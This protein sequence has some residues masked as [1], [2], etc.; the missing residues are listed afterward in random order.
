MGA[1]SLGAYIRIAEQ[2]LAD[3]PGT[4]QTYRTYWRR[5]EEE[6]GADTPL[7]TILTSQ[8]SAL[9]R[10]SS[11][12]AVVR[13]NTRQGVSAQENFVMAARFLFRSAVEDR[14]IAE[15][16]AAKVPIPK[17]EVSFRRALS[18]AELERLRTLIVRY[19]S[20]P[21]LDL[22]LVRFH[23]ETGAR[24]GGA[25]AL[26]RQDLSREGQWVLLREKGNHSR[27]QPTTSFL[28]PAL[29]L[30][31]QRRYDFGGTVRH[32]EVFLTKNGAPIGRRHY[33]TLFGRLARYDPWVAEQGISAHWLRHTAA[34]RIERYAGTAVASG[35]LGHL[36]SNATEEY[37]KT[38]FEEIA[39]AVCGLAGETHPSDSSRSSTH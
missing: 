5:M 2:A 32:D 22:L 12:A 9:A 34:T 16:P 17:R 30:F 33:D 8:V 18:D 15:S 29:E 38:S 7:D 24:R 31:R 20:D 39:K 28:V 23:L 6:W 10:R 11:K 14:V 3:R 27:R 4:L 26:R 25:L 1:V 13:R 37:V 36:P 35:F 19:S 21:E